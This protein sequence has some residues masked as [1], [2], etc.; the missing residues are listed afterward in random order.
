MSD[1]VRL[2]SFNLAAC[3]IGNLQQEV[4]QPLQKALDQNE[5]KRRRPSVKKRRRLGFTFRAAQNV[6]FFRILGNNLKGNSIST[7]KG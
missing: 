2:F 3:P 7:V 4:D 5:G 6:V 1:S